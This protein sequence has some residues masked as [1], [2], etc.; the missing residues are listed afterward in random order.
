MEVWKDVLG[1]EGYYE[2]SD[3]GR[4]RSVERRIVRNDGISQ[5]RKSKVLS[6]F[7]NKDGYM[8]V[9]LCSCGNDERIAVHRLVAI[10]FVDGYEDG[11]E[12]NH[13]DCRRDNNVAANLEWVS[14]GKNVAYA[15]ACG[16]HQCTRDL[17]GEKNPNYGSH[18]LR[19][20]YASDPLLSKEKQSRPGSRNGRAVE[21]VAKRDSVC[22]RFGTI[23]ECAEWFISSG[24]TDLSNV[25]TVSFRVSTAKK[26]GCEYCGFS[27]I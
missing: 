25:S 6:Q 26:S 10:A 20:R 27:I 3:L 18:T 5:V 7:K 17:T 1:Y 11:M 15:I 24:I 14:H 4:V 12:V 21:V 22:M 23:K 19:D 8:S 2:V 9:H 16:N 13:K